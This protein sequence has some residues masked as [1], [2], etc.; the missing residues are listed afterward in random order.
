M[1][2]VVSGDQ[3]TLVLDASKVHMVDDVALAS[4]AVRTLCDGEARRALLT[5][6]GWVI[7]DDRVEL[8]RV[9]RDAFIAMPAWLESVRWPLAAL[10]RIDEGFGCQ[11]D[12]DRLFDGPFDFAPFDGAEGRPP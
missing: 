11:I 6:R 8:R 2:V 7:V 9:D 12:I 10:V 1:V 5:D 4:G 3:H